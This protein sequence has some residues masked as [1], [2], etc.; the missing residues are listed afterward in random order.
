MNVYWFF[1]V[2]SMIGCVVCNIHPRILKVNNHYEERARLYQALILFGIVIVFCGLRSGV[3]DTPAYIDEFNSAVTNIEQLDIAAIQKDKGY[4]ILEVLFKQFVSTDYH[5]WLFLIACISG[6]AVMYTL[7]KHSVDFGM[8]FFLYI[9]T[10]EFTWLMNGMRQY[11]VISLLFVSVDLLLEKKI[12]KYLIIVILLS[13]IHGTA[14]IMIPI[15]FIAHLKP[16]SWKIFIAVCCMAIMGLNIEAFEFLFDNTQ[17]EGYLG[18]IIGS[19]GMNAL[20]FLVAVVPFVICIWAKKI[21]QYEND[22]LINLCV[23]MECFYLAIQFAA[24]FI[25]ANY[26]GRLAAYFGIYSLLLLPWLMKKCF[27]PR[28]SKIVKLGCIG[29]YIIYFYYQM[30]ITWK[31]DYISDIINI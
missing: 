10:T 20:R 15:Y 25:G 19:A 23:N 13:T 30:V 5:V 14:L 6:M 12:W 17:Y 18:E 27:T 22:Q 2:M 4:V 16:F 7:Y 31:L 28:S 8:S 11:L 24:L 9:A 29:F 3:A 1:L 21:I 26:L